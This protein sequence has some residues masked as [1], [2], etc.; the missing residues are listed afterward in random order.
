MAD[1]EGDV[2][3]QGETSGEETEGHAKDCLHCLILKTIGEA[4]PKGI[5]PVEM[6][7]ALGHVT[8]Q[9]IAEVEIDNESENMAALLMGKHL[10][11]MQASYLHALSAEVIEGLPDALVELMQGIGDRPVKRKM[12]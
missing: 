10:I 6:A 1:N 11:A 9:V 3:T 2:K 12:H 5:D 8:G 7:E 4:R